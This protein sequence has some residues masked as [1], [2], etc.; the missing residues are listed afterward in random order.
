[1]RTS[2]AD[3][4]GFEVI[5]DTNIPLPKSKRGGGSIRKWPF[6]EMEIGESFAV[7]TEVLFK[8]ARSA[9][10]LYKKKV[11]S[12]WNYAARAQGAGG[13]IWRTR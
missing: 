7:P 6:D 11:G 3:E 12:G 1:M 13:R 9:A 4:T 2:A 5:I 8:R 10:S